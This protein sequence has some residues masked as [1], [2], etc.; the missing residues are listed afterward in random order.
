MIRRLLEYQKYRKAAEQLVDR[1]LLERQVWTRGAEE[2]KPNPDDQPLRQ[3]SSFALVEALA[4]AMAR[5]KVKQVHDVVVDRISITD[6][7]NEL[8]DSLRDIGAVRF[9]DCFNTDKPPAQLRH[10]LVVTFMAVL[11]M[12]RL[13][14]V[15]I[16]Q[17]EDL[18][19]IYLKGTEALRNV[20]DV[21]ASF[22]PPPEE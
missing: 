9:F 12:A 13:G 19:D 15:S 2:E 3:V 6:R 7:L 1:P 14:M 16:L 5:V 22:E 10:E 20:E 8:V 11:E 4:Q 17:H 18:G 21:E